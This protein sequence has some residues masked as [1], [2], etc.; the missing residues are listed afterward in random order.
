M[1]S[2]DTVQYYPN[3]LYS[4]QADKNVCIK[5]IDNQYNKGCV[6]L[7]NIDSGTE[8]YIESPHIR[9]RLYNESITHNHQSTDHRNNQLPMYIC[10]YCNAYFTDNLPE[11]IGKQLSHRITSLP[12]VLSDAGTPIDHCNV[13]LDLTEYE[14]AAVYCRYGCGEVYCNQQ[15]RDAAFLQYHELLCTHNKSD[16]SQQLYTV[17][18]QQFIQHAQ[19]NNETFIMLARIFADIYLTYKRIVPPDTID[20]QSMSTAMYSYLQYNNELWH[21]QKTQYMY[22]TMH[23]NEVDQHKQQLYEICDASYT[24]LSA[25]FKPLIGGELYTTYFTAELF[26][27]LLAAI[28]MN[29]YKITTRSP[30]YFYYQHIISLPDT[31]QQSIIAS[32]GNEIWQLIIDEN[33]WVAVGSGLFRVTCC[34]NHSCVPNVVVD[35]PAIFTQT[36]VDV[37]GVDRDVLYVDKCDDSIVVIT[38]DDIPAG[39]QL[40]VS[41]IDENAELDER[42]EEIGDYMFTCKCEKCIDERMNGKS[43]KFNDDAK[44]SE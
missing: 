41:Y 27:R 30:L 15:C 31:E 32:L 19:A 29:Q 3:E 34:I 42:T 28:E 14:H 23:P 24:L 22:H 16:D 1:N 33:E 6:V 39:G 26:S 5:H 10:D 36:S 37:N 18:I 4:I 8:L 9:C 20:A 35:K 43:T 12:H 25:A 11:Y 2:L 21:I 44:M 7:D 17:S 38:L 40:F 13:L